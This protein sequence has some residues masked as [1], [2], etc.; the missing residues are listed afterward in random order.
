MRETI[1]PGGAPGDARGEAARDEAAV[2]RFV[3]RFAADLTEAGMQRM[4]ARV[5]AALLVSDSGALTS[6]ELAERLRISPA[7]VS[8]AIRYLSQVDMVVRE[9][10]PGSRR[11]RYRLYNNGVW[12]ETLTRRD[13]IV[14]RWEST[15][16]DGAKVLGP[17]TPAGLR[18]TETADFF[19]FVQRELP[20]MLERW[21]AQQAERR[22][23]EA[24]EAEAG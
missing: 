3:E 17:D 21:R 23:A 15:M 12:Y 24:R 19:E 16:R 18:I 13:Q 4:A 7:A 20:K 6:A 14:A 8:G 5:L 22:A 1:E 2:S 10:E 11:D 9:R